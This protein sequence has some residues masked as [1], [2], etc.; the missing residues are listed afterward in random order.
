VGW[1]HTG[2]CFP[3]LPF[4]HLNGPNIK[5]QVELLTIFTSNLLSL[6]IDLYLPI[7][8][9][10]PM[11]SSGGAFGGAKGYQ[12][13]PPEK[14]VFPL[15]H[16]GEC[17][18]AKEDYM[19][20][21]REHSGDASACRDAARRY[22]ACRMEKNLMAQQDLKDLG[23]DRE[24]AGASVQ[25]HVQSAERDKEARYM[26]EKEGFVAGSRFYADR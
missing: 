18:T 4:N 19:A 20:C 21:L 1:L 3:T 17:K 5:A 16:F 10:E 6:P 24:G 15:D 11:A 22:L 12:P 2:C 14:G 9:H 26:R 8:V 25:Q 23:F 7:Y 13:R